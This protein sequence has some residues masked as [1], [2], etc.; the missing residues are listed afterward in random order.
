[1]RRISLALTVLATLALAVPAAAD[2]K[3]T[4]AEKAAIKPVALA[5]CQ[6]P[7][8]ECRFHGA[9]VS[10]ANARFAWANVTNEGFSGA[11]LKRPTRR[12]HRFRVIGTQGGGIGECSYWRARAPRA[13]PRDLGIAG[14]VGDD[15]EVRNCGKRG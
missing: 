12:S 11:L 6:S 4:K 8:G 1:M 10:T 7:A 3:A 15:Y 2:R 13:V 5:S 14:L 9:R